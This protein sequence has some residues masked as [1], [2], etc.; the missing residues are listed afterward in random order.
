MSDPPPGQPVKTPRRSKRWLIIALAGAVAIAAVSFVFSPPSGMDDEAEEGGHPRR[1]VFHV[2]HKPEPPKLGI[3]YHFDRNAIVDSRLLGGK[4][5]VLAASGNLVTFDAET[6][7]VRREKVLRRRATCLGPADKTHVLACISNGSI[8][9]VAVATL[10]SRRLRTFPASPSGLA[11]GR[12]MARWSSPTVPR[13]ATAYSSG[14]MVRAAP[15]TLGAGAGPVSRQQGSALVRQRW[16]GELSR[17]RDERAQR[18][19]LERRVARV[20]RLRRAVG[21]A[22]LGLW[23]VGSIGRDGE[24]CGSPAARAEAGASVWAGGKR[25]VQAAP[26]APITHVLEDQDPARVLVV[27]HDGTSVSDANLSNWQPLDAMVAGHR[28]NDATVA[29]GQAHIAGHRVLVT[30]ARGGFMEFTAEF[31]RRHFLD[32]QDSV[33]RPSA[34]V[35]LTSG[36]SFY[37]EGGPLF[38]K[39]GGWHPL[40]DPIMPPAELMGLPRSGEKE[41][42]WVAMTTIPIEGE[43]SYVIAKAGPPRN[44]VATSTACATSS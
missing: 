36:M 15:M 8:V 7:K 5:L 12:R 19:G 31:T 35:R 44:Y 18:G 39:G 3:E 9:R 38:Y 4:S 1:V 26:T 33:F 30:L 20:A 6:F 32:G 2:K 28:E 27:S 13:R 41:R 22:N 16:H 29:L 43:I 10:A 40:P 24:L 34:I 11:S 42:L 17:S 14:M 37:G 23:R 25:P 21:W